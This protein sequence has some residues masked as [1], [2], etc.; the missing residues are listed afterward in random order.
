LKECVS[1]VKMEGG[2]RVLGWYR[3]TIGIE[4]WY[5]VGPGSEDLKLFVCTSSNVTY[6]R[7]REREYSGLNS[8]MQPNDMTRTYSTCNI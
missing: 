4:G 5:Y 2:W 1:S 3:R 7:E 6:I 8:Y